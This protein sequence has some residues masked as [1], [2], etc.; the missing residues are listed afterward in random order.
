MCK[1][2]ESEVTGHAPVV[3]LRV[4]TEVYYDHFNEHVVIFE[5]CIY[6]LQTVLMYCL[7]KVTYDISPPHRAATG[8]NFIHPTKW[9]WFE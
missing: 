7:I 6:F 9:I 8:D 4:T 3:Q 1:W 2:Q 5:I